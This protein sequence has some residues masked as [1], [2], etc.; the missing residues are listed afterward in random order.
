MSTL[1]AV[2]GPVFL[3]IGLGYLA[4]R[5]NAFSA[6][7]ADALMSFA[8]SFAIPC[9]LFRAIST[10]DLGSHF[11]WPLLV[12]YYTGSVAVFVIAALGARSLF[13]RGA[14][15][16]IAIGFAAMFAN[17]VLLG[18]PV[19]ERAFGTAALDPNYAIIAI[20]APICYLV[21]ITTMEVARNRE[22]GLFTGL[23]SVAKSMASNGLM[24]G[25]GLGFVVNLGGIHIPEP[26]TEALDLMARAALPAALF[27]LGGILVRYRPE[28]D[29]MQIG[30]VCL[31]SL[32]VHPLIVLGMAGLTGISTS[33]MQSAVITAA[34]APGVNAF[35][36]ASMYGSAKRVAASAVLI[37][38]F[39]SILTVS[40]WLTLIG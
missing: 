38:T 7:N 31:I 20:H 28:G 9:L 37:G 27:A 21:G 25:I 40:V 2:T 6:S 11:D 34:M 23:W 12:S 8:Q 29:L 33:A 13:G 3:V 36:F 19:T 32:V 15:D 24:I 17:S 35:I 5:L 18:L 10:L 26:A 39:S 1:L 4:V 14:T 22:S 16:A 30:F